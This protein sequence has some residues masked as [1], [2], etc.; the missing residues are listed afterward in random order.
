MVSMNF[1][2]ATAGFFVTVAALAGGWAAFFATS[3]VRDVDAIAFAGAEGTGGAGAAEDG[4]ESVG[5]GDRPETEAVVVGAV[6][7][8]FV[9]L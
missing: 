4:S 9:A 3:V 7:P 2:F 8:L 5:D 1:F 6:P